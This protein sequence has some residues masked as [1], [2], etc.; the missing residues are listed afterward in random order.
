[1]GGKKEYKGDS[2]V[3]LRVGD[4]GRK[5]TINRE[6]VGQRTFCG[7]GVVGP[8]LEPTIRILAKRGGYLMIYG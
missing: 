5:T 4:I 6:E 8:G 1:V 2:N 7:P 3:V